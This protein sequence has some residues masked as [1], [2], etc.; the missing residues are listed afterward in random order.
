MVRMP[1]T[2]QAF[3]TRIGSI[4]TLLENPANTHGAGLHL[5]LPVR[6]SAC[7]LS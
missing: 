2:A 4:H 6:A 7:T 3:A 5:Q 1:T